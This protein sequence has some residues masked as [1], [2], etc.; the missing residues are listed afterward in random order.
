MCSGLFALGLE[1]S[2]PTP[3]WELP[4]QLEVLHLG[5]NS[6]SGKLPTEWSLPAKL[7]MINLEGNDFSGGF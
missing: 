6:L 2:I 3:G 5:D 4:A 1:G 7:S